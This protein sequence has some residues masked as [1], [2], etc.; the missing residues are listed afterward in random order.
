MENFLIEVRKFVY[1]EIKKT[2]VP[3]KAQADF[4]TETGKILAR[5]LG[6]NIDVV[7]AGTLLMDCMLGQAN[8]ENRREERF[9]FKSR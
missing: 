6:A 4:A 2:G 8:R 7:E 3:D 9:S 1:D 5:K